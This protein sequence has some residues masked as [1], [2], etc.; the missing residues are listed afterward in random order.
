MRLRR[1]EKARVGVGPEK[2]FETP[3]HVFLRFIRFLA[4]VST[5]TFLSSLLKIRILRKNGTFFYRFLRVSTDEKTRQLHLIVNSS[6]PNR[7]GR[8]DNGFE[9]LDEANRSV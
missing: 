1:G 5:R 7:S 6:I 4:F 9:A 3:L 2:G 8:S